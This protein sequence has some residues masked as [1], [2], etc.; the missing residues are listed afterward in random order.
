MADILDPMK[1]HKNTWKLVN[2]ALG[3]EVEFTGRVVVKQ[4]FK[5]LEMTGIPLSMSYREPAGVKILTELE[6]CAPV[7]IRDKRKRCDPRFAGLLI[8]PNLSLRPDGLQ[9]PDR[10]PG[11]N[12]PTA[13]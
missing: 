5:E 9:T 7:Y 2:E 13:L 8:D 6:D 3:F 4:E 1:D 12:P 11:Q 10:R